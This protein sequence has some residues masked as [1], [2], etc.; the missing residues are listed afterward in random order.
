MSYPTYKI[1]NITM[2]NCQNGVSINN[3]AWTIGSTQIAKKHVDNIIN[4]S[5]LELTIDMSD[6][7]QVL[8][9]VRGVSLVSGVSASPTSSSQPRQTIPTLVSESP[10]VSSSSFT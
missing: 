5:D 9:F 6:L 3:G 2:L 4:N 10:C 7:G 1:G 8:T